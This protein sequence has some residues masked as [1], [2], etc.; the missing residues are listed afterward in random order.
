MERVLPPSSSNRSDSN[1]PRSLFDNDF[2]AHH[3]DTDDD[4]M[5]TQPRNRLAATAPNRKMSNWLKVFLWIS[6]LGTLTT[7]AG[8]SF[9]AF[10]YWK[11][12][13]PT[14]PD[15]NELKTVQMQ[16][17][18][19]IYTS[20]N[21]LMAEYGEKRR[22]PLSY[23]QFPPQM[24]QAILAAED[25][26]F[27]E[28]PGV[29]YQG[30]LRA[31]FELVKT[32]HK[33]Q[34]GSTITMQVA[35]N[36]F[37]S[38]EKSFMRKINEIVLSFKIEHELSKEEIIALYLNKIF[39]GHR[40]YGFAAAAQTYF[41]RSIDQ[42]TVDEFAILA[43][44]PKAPS[45]LN[46]VT[47][48]E[49]SKSRRD[50][51]LRR[52]TE[53]G[54]ISDAE[55]QQAQSRPVESAIHNAIIEANGDYISEMI[56]QW[57]IEK[58]GENALEQGLT[59]TTTIRADL[60]TQAQKAINMG[61]FGYERRHGYR[62]PVSVLDA[63]AQT[64][65]PNSVKDI[66]EP[67]DLTLAL[68]IAWND[69][70]RVANIKLKDGSVQQLDSKMTDWAKGFRESGRKNFL[71]VGDVIYVDKQIDTWRLA[72]V[73][74]IQSALASID[75]KTGAILALSGGYDFSRNQ[76]NR[77]V[78]AR[79]QP[80]SSF[81]PFLYTAALDKGYTP[82]TLIND[83]PITQYDEFSE[84]Y[85]RPENYTGKFG[86]P[87]RM[88][89]ALIH[90]LN[91]VSI[92]ILQDIGIDYFLKYAKG[93]GINTKEMESIRNLSISLGTAPFSLL[94][95]TGNYAMFSNGGYRVRPYFVSNVT[96]PKGNKIYEAAIPV[97]CEENCADNTAA[98][99][100]KAKTHYLITSMMQDVVRMGTGHGAM[101]LKRN[102][103]AG[104]TGTTNDIKDTW[105]MGF[106]PDIVTGVWMGFDQPDSMG[107]QESGG[108]SSLPI[109]VDYMRLALKDKPDLGAYK[110]PEGIVTRRIDAIT[111][112]LIADNKTEG[113]SEVFDQDNLP[114]V[115]APDPLR[116]LQHELF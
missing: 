101:V 115:A 51:V 112:E 61:V 15:V 40:S 63:S 76:F 106:N 16:V 65:W 23:E 42:L 116:E 57:A 90:S 84:D 89:S 36:F 79:R 48:P 67:D 102:D 95:H 62:G 20:D 12:I 104:K 44:L 58:F 55:K 64:Q 21:K 49:A 70:T 83:A 88:R 59:I 45:T 99:V 52:M 50:Y 86:G 53:L 29:D 28:H 98:R 47:N 72:Q 56:R 92:R 2:P 97:F 46:P 68:V 37:L 113:I 32:G 5:H 80:G 69:K 87:T 105:F 43:G 39:L 9:A 14:L 54:Y 26:R 66:A 18:L 82:A 17:P 25:D 1:K 93:L 114:E 34:G 38:P 103:L 75:S 111:G 107:K 60:Q 30:I 22:I 31:V 110:K 10:T 94:E 8:V 81:K 13:Y 73:P 35:R 91:L 11:T 7:V 19:R 27:F 41:G 85:W 71:Q 3:A 4:S 74:R 108:S 24:I 96:D 33:S 6:F 77:A 78:Q 109:W 100:I